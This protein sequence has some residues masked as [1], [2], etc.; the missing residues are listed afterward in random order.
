MVTDLD[1]DSLKTINTL[2][3]L[4]KKLPCSGLFTLVLDHCTGIIRYHVILILKL[5]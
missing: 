2:L 3:S 5:Q 1:T 4:G